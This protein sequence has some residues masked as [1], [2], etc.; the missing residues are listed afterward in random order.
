[1]LALSLSFLFLRRPPCSTLFPYTT[2]FR[3]AG[4][5]TAEVFFD[6]ARVPAEALVGGQEGT[7]FAAAMSSL[8]RGRLHIAAICVGLA[9]RIVEDRK[10]TRLNSSHVKISYAVFCLKKKKNN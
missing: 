10:S 6:D 1:S 7:G 2:L 4:A 5:H 8:T 9:G 3:S